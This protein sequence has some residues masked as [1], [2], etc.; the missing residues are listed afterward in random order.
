MK[1]RKLFLGASLVALTAV[2]LSSC[3]SSTTRNT[4]TPYGA[5]NSKL[6]ETFATADGDLKMTV[7]QYYTQLR[8]KG[9][10][11]I[12]TSINKKIYENEYQ[13]IKALYENDTRAAFISAVGKE[14]L[15]YLEFTDESDDSKTSQKKLYDL[16]ADSTEANDKYLD[17]R[18]KLIK[19]IM[20]SFANSIYSKATV[21]LINKMTAEEKETAIKKYVDTV[22]DEGIYIS[23]S[24]IALDEASTYFSSEEN[25]PMF[26]AKTIKALKDKLEDLLLN[27]ARLLASRKE[28]Y[29]V[30]DE[31]YIYDEDSDTDIKNSNYIFKDSSY[32]TTFNNRFKKYGKYNA[33]IIQFNSRKEAMDAINAIGEIPADD[34]NA[35]KAKYLD[36]YNMYYGYKASASSTDDEEFNY[37]VNENKDDLSDLS[38]SIS[39]FITDTLEDGQ[40]LTEPRNINNK[41]VMALRI[42]TKY[43][44]YVDDESKQADY[45]DFSGDKKTE[46]DEMIKEELLFS[47]SNYTTT[48]DKNRYKA[49]NIKIYD[50]YFEN[51][52]YNSYSDEYTLIDTTTKNEDENIYTIGDYKY[53]VEDFYKDASK[54][55]SN[56]ILTNYFELE[57]ANTYYSKFV[58][59]YL[60]DSDLETTNKD[61]LTEAIKTFNNNGNTTYAKEL[62]LETYLLSAYGYTTESDVL[63]YYYNAQKA[64]TVYNSMKV[65]DSW[66][67]SSADENGNYSVSSSASEGFLKYL[68]EMGNAHYSDLFGIN[69]DHILINI[70]DNA[71]GSPDDPDSFLLEKTDAEKQ[72]FTNAVVELAQAIYKESINDAY[73]NSTLL[74]TLKFIKVQYEEGDSKLLSDP[75]KT[76]NDFKKYNFLLTVESLASSGNITEESV[77]N[78]VVPFKEYVIELYKSVSTLGSTD[79]YKKNS[80]DG[81]SY[82]YENGK[83][84]LVNTDTKEGSFATTDADASKITEKTLCKTVYGYHLLVLNSYEKSKYLTY[85]SS[86]ASEYQQN[87]ELT[88]RTYTDSDDKT[89]TI[90]LNISSINEPD[91]A[92]EECVTA[93]F[94]QFF[95]Y[96]VQKANGASTSLDSSIYEIMAKL[97]DEPINNYTS[98][99]FQ[100][101]L[102]LKKLNIQVKD[103]QAGIDNKTIETHLTKLQN[104]IINYEKDSDYEIWFD[105]AY[106]WTRPEI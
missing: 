62:G 22:A 103:T 11:V 87:I 34:I 48:V 76:W 23:A 81:S 82:E 3:G 18:K 10:D 6:N 27:Q 55:F 69:L 13:V 66:R 99:G 9:Y 5:L 31:E 25:V 4:V 83:F 73:K 29:K 85:T 64:L 104:N 7:G 100:E 1:I 45:S 80:S 86:S 42:S 44:Y 35:A 28:L 8:K 36:L 26:Q 74:D 33:V 15:S 46:I 58:S 57:F 14:K 68:L 65:Y 102:L 19:E 54:K 75:T 41:Y 90:D 72:D 61:T 38:S 47:N 77:N 24:D 52:F 30:A 94:N 93:S 79:T 21:E 88:L 40:Y 20:T 51:Q 70:D 63:K 53:S 50:P 17:L 101:Y 105:A 95:I 16:S 97:F 60:I 84:Y 96:Y 67:S 89:Q 98:S 78:F 37:V 59:L 106:D 56:D 92:G 71:D 43:D 32:K 91:V 2:T 39:T 12:T 49:A